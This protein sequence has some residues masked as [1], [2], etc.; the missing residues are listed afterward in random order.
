MKELNM[1][2]YL[3]EV[4]KFS[5]PLS[6]EKFVPFVG[7]IL[8]ETYSAMDRLI[9]STQ[10]ED[11]NLV[12]AQ[13]Y[14]MKIGLAISQ[15][16]IDVVTKDEVFNAIDD[17]TD[18]IGKITSNPRVAEALRMMNSKLIESANKLVQDREKILEFEAFVE[19]YMEKGGNPLDLTDGDI[20]K[21][22]N[23][24]EEL[25]NF[26]EGGV[27]D[28]DLKDLKRGES[29]TVEVGKAGD[30]SRVYQTAVRL[31][32]QI[33]SPVRSGVITGTVAAYFPS[34]LTGGVTDQTHLLVKVN[35]SLGSYREF[36]IT[37]YSGEITNRGDLQSDAKYC[38]V[39]VK[40]TR[41]IFA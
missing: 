16:A 29:K 37:S 17:L 22:F 24:S 9:E 10:K 41:N 3:E 19:D 30:G 14:Q 15:Y 23:G 34:E 40:E 13:V 20:S 11:M 33:G 5:L 8:K 28:K 4:R 6:I 26:L 25:R 21:I 39:L 32:F 36:D 35:S 18:F 1:T 7:E 12:R 31:P 38:K 2:A 27:S